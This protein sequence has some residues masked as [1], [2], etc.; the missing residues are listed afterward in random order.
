AQGKLALWNQ[1]AAAL[2]QS[3]EIVMIGY[4]R[5]PRL[6]PSSCLR[7]HTGPS[8]QRP[9]D[10]QWRSRTA[11]FG[12]NRTGG[13]RR[14]WSIECLRAPLLHALHAKSLANKNVVHQC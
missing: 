5:P 13:R 4:S 6:A 3:T 12:V 9:A 8:L 2:R 14:F 11:R 10:S 1:A 7:W